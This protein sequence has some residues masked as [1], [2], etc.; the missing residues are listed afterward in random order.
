MLYSPGAE[1]STIKGFLYWRILQALPSSLNTFTK[2]SLSTKNTVI[3]ISSSATSHRF[4]TATRKWSWAL[5]NVLWVFCLHICLHY[6]YAWYPRGQKKALD[7]LQLGNGCRDAILWKSSRCSSAQNH[8]STHSF[9]AFNIYTSYQGIL[10]WHCL[11]FS[12]ATEH[13]VCFFF[14]VPAAAVHQLSLATIASS[15]VHT[16]IWYLL[17]PDKTA[18]ASAANFFLIAFSCKMTS[19]IHPVFSSSRRLPQRLKALRASPYR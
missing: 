10:F 13:L 8:L 1:F 2:W 3:S 11:W 6:M 4:L 18:L 7:S 14:E 19:W 9:W 16:Y 12:M 5:K 17:P 15:A